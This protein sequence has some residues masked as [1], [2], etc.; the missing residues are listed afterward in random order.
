M[1]DISEADLESIRQRKLAEMQKAQQAQSAREKARAEAIS[2]IEMAMKIMLAPDAWDQWNNAK[3][4]NPENALIAATELI[5][6]SQSGKISGKITK[7]QI[8]GILSAI[9][10]QTHRDIKIKRK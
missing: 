5:R 10:S 1:A 9:Y 6:L 2:Q 4:S 8:K 7:E 3:I